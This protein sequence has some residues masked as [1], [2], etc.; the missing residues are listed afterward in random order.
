MPLGSDEHA[1]CM[2]FSRRPTYSA[3][4]ALEGGDADCWRSKL[5]GSWADA[6]ICQSFRQPGIHPYGEVVQVCSPGARYITGH[7][8]L[9]GTRLALTVAR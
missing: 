6:V 4:H 7:A 5:D 2:C 9:G 8:V 3:P 1:F